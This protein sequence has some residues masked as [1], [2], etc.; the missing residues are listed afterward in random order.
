MRTPWQRV[1]LA[2]YCALVGAVIESA[3][4]DSEHWR[5][6]YLLLGVL[7]GLMAAA[8]RYAETPLP[9]MVP[10]LARPGRTA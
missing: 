8:Q 7:W 10:T 6:I 3:I 1:Y 9:A 2:A 5:H 4:I